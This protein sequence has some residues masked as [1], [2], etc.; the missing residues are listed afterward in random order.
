M[1]DCSGHSMQLGRQ[2][3]FSLQQNDIIIKKSAEIK[4]K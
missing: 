1:C 4:F 3:I 2:F